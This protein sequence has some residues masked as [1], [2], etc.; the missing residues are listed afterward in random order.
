M[1]PPDSTTESSAPTAVPTD[2]AAADGANRALEAAARA[3]AARW[4]WPAF[5]LAALLLLADQWTKFAAIDHLA[6]HQHPMVVEAD[7]SRTVAQLF[8]DRGVLDGEVAA[9]VGQRWVW[10]YDRAI[11]L[12]AAMTL[13]GL[14]APR[15]L[16][17]TQGTGFPP[18]RRVRIDAADAS[19]T[20]GVVLAER[21]RVPQGQV[22]RL[23]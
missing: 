19:R 8:A 3:A 9:A 11:G 22:D 23:L 16:I 15:Q 1:P 18:P 17:A 6:T 7:G 12:T 4:R 10:R 5:A 14:G 20:L 21:W 2:T 13:D